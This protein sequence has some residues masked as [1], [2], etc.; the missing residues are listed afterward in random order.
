MNNLKNMIVQKT[1]DFQGVL[2]FR[3]IVEHHRNGAQ[4]LNLYTVMIAFVDARFG[5][6]AIV[7][8]LT[9]ELI[10]NHHPCAARAMMIQANESAVPEFLGPIGHIF[11]ND[12][13]MNI[14]HLRTNLSSAS[15]T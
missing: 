1:M 5:A 6:P 9:E 14:N 2:G 3:P 15:I 7:L 11:G 10:V 12:V 8:N 4:Y 13:G